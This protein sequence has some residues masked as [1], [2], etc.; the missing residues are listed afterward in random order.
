MVYDIKN[1]FC[2]G[3]VRG[4]GAIIDVMEGIKHKHSVINSVLDTLR[5]V[6]TNA[7]IHST[8]RVLST[9]FSFFCYIFCSPI[10][11][12]LLILPLRRGDRYVFES[13]SQVMKLEF[14]NAGAQ[15]VAVLIV[16]Q[17]TVV[18]LTTRAALFIVCNNMDQ[19]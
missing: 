14:T 19:L 15:L 6:N 7:I 13:A 5:R 11:N 4:A 1:T 18:P 10:H 12:E 17:S 8:L 9:L 2:L 3:S 16:V